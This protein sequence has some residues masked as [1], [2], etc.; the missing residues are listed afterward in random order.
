MRRFV[1]VRAQQQQ[2]VRSA[3][4]GREGSR[5]RSAMPRAPPAPADAAARLL[6]ASAEAVDASKRSLMT[7]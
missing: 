6:Q 4:R 7:G 2:Q 3:A 1:T 5:C